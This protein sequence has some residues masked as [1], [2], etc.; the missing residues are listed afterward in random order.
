[1][2]NKRGSARGVLDWLPV[3]EEV[4]TLALVSSWGFAC[5]DCRAP[6]LDKGVDVPPGSKLHRTSPL[7]RLANWGDSQYQTYGVVVDLRC[8]FRR[9][10]TCK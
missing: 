2:R 1:M 10:T 9:E 7:C 5:L 4:N 3:V 8:R 6:L